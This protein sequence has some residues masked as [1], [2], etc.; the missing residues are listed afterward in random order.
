MSFLSGKPFM[1]RLAARL[2]FCAKSQYELTCR[3]IKLDKRKVFV[4]ATHMRAAFGSTHT[5]IAL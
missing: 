4:L 1:L 2:A 5:P 3:S